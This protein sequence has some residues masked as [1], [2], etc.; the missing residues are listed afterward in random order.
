[1]EKYLIKKFNPSIRLA[2]KYNSRNYHLS[3][4]KV[5]NI[6]MIDSDN[7]KVMFHKELKEGQKWNIVQEYHGLYSITYGTNDYLMEGWHL[8]YDLKNN[9]IL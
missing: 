4:H 7:T 5:F 6:E 1:M 2:V 3:C 9:F 8:Y